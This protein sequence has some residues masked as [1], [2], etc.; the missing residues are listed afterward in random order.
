M[1]FV[2]FLDNFSKEEN[3]FPKIYYPSLKYVSEKDETI[4]QK[5]E[6]FQGKIIKGICQKGKY[7][8]PNGQEFFGDLSPN[9]K[10]NKRGKIIF[11][12]KD[13]LIGI[14][15]SENNTIEKAIYQTPTKIYQG[16][17]KNNLF[18]GKFIIKN[19]EKK[20]PFH[21]LFIGSYFNGLKDG[22][23][24]LETIYN[25]E[26]I[27]VTGNFCKGRKNGT[28]KI[29]RLKEIKIDEKNNKVKE[30]F[31]KEF[32]YAND[33]LI[34]SYKNEKKIENK[35]YFETNEKNKIF[36][37]EII[38]EI[39]KKL[40]FCLGSY[41][42]LLI[43]Y[44]NMENKTINFEKKI[45]LF[46]KENIK[47]I[48]RLSDG[49]ILLCTDNNNFKLIKMYLEKA[50][51]DPSSIKEERSTTTYSTDNDFRLLQNFNGLTKSKNISSLIELSSD[52]IVSGDSENI[53]VWKKEYIT[54][55]D[56][57]IINEDEN[58]KSYELK[59]KDYTN[60]NLSH[61]FC[62]LKI[63]EENN[64]II[65][66]VAQPDSKS[67]HF[68][69]IS[70]EG[71]IGDNVKIIGDKNNE[72]KSLNCKH[73]MTVF[74]NELLVGCKNQIIIIDINQ[75]K[76]TNKLYIDS[77]IAFISPYLNRFLL[78]GL[79]KRKNQYNYEGY[80]SQRDISNNFINNDIKIV[81][82]SDFKK[83]HEG[84]IIDAFVYNNNDNDHNQQ[85]IITIGTDGKILLL[86]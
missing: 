75:Y 12:N 25:N 85:L 57:I 4:F 37:I 6:T 67:I 14:F 64:Y 65:L 39:D 60:K 29:Y 7:T 11:T 41:E 62:M 79:S 82:I 9:N 52:L 56:T 53:I 77:S 20:N 72:I 23:F 84:S 16:S 46:K 38:E 5:G 43:Y 74:N 71:N 73:I 83:R 80:L 33:F 63:K 18:N 44:I 69:E 50:D 30:E 45:N 49:N 54:D 22:K 61:T 86:Y 21:Y 28:F 2:Q 76:I 78:L 19:N 32:I 27:K 34:K 48:L 17:F 47:D 13:E 81:N 10:F 8:W 70:Y 3:I 35:K 55:N 42:A 51:P 26:K 68:I 36:C 58:K 15:N 31:L 24:T 40:Y 66:A 59:Q 1:N